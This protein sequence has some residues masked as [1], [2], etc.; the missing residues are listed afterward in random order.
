M[1]QPAWM[2]ATTDYAG[3]PVVLSRATWHATAGHDAPGTPPEI[4]G[5]LEAVRTT[6]ASPHRVF[7]STSD[8]RSCLFSR[9]GA[10]QGAF[11]GTPVVVVE[12]YPEKKFP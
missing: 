2:F 12:K 10:G 7:A 1:V 3:T 8:T 5:D 4:R 11:A 9:R 6:I